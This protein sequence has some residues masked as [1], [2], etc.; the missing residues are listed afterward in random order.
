MYLKKI[1]AYRDIIAIS[2]SELLGKK[3]VEGKKQLDIKETFYK[4]ELLSEKE[5]EEVMLFGIKE[6]ATFNIVGERAI[7]LAIKI[8]LITK[9]SV[10][11]I[12][13]IPYS[14]ILL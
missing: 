4:G 14:L 5:V 10:G 11:V 13:K 2:D 12:D 9:E 8:G 1:P 3:F 6:D 7:N